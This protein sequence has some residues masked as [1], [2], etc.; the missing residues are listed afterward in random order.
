MILDERLKNEWLVKNEIEIDRTPKILE[1]KTDRLVKN[2]KIKP[3][4]DFR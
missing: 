1:M 3:P 2:E 4:I